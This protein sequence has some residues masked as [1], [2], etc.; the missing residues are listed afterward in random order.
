MSE[1]KLHR[2]YDFIS[3]NYILNQACI[4]P[5]LVNFFFFFFRVISINCTINLWLKQEMYHSGR[6]H[7]IS[8]T[9]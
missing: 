6:D 4:F 2:I 8:S 7:L 1:A 3:E 5:P 9:N